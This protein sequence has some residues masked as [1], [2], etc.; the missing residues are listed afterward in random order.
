MHTRL[1]D[2]NGFND[3]DLDLDPEDELEEEE[4]SGDDQDLLEE[5]PVD[6]SDD[7]S[8]D[9]L[10]ECGDCGCEVSDYDLVCPGCGAEFESEDDDDG[11]E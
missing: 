10:D 8:D 5:N 7:E 4:E 6:G 11:E 1:S 9:E 3:A 2:L